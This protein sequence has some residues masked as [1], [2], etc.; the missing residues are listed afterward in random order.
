MTIDDRPEDEPFMVGDKVAP[1]VRGVTFNADGD[2]LLV[3]I[4]LEQSISQLAYDFALGFSPAALFFDLD[5]DS[6]TGERGFAGRV[7]FELTLETSVGV[8]YDRDSDSYFWAGGREA[9]AIVDFACSHG[10]E[11]MVSMP[12][13][14]F[15]RAWDDEPKQNTSCSGNTLSLRV[16]YDRLGVEPGQVVRIATEESMGS[17]KVAQYYL[18]D[19]LLTF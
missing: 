10:I 8:R 4:Q 15:Y 6:K 16:S 9:A 14:G 5:N 17:G 12:N 18:D 1:D 3:H 13:P 11:P 19:A 2:S 7:G